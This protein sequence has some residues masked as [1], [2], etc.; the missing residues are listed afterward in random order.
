MTDARE[1]CPPG[2][3][4]FGEVANSAYTVPRLLTPVSSPLLHLRSKGKQPMR[5]LA[6][7]LLL[8]V[9]WFVC[10]LPVSAQYAH[11]AR[12]TDTILVNGNTA[13]NGAATY[14]A[15]VLLTANSPG[16]IFR[17]SRDDGNY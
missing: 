14:E 13:L 5:L 10:L 11:F 3:E 12:P 6:A 2:K 16:L 7:F 17:E 4:F 15:R 1:Y 9:I 8:V